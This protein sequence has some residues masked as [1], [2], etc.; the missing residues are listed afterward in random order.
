M[1]VSTTV[2]EI[3][4]RGPRD[5]TSC[6]ISTFRWWSD[7][8]D[9]LCE[10]LG[11]KKKKPEIFRYDRGDWIRDSEVPDNK[12]YIS[13]TLDEETALKFVK[14]F[15][16]DRQIYADHGFR[17]KTGMLLYGPPG[18]GK[19][20]FVYRMAIEDNSNVYVVSPGCIR[21]ASDLHS[22]IKNIEDNSTVYFEDFDGDDS[23]KAMD[24]SDDDDDERPRRG[25]KGK[26]RSSAEAP[27]KILQSIL[28]GSF[29]PNN[30]TIFVFSTNNIDKL[31]NED[32]ETPLIR[33]ARI[34]LTIE[35][36]YATSEWVKKR[37]LLD[38]PKATEQANKLAEQLN[39][40]TVVQS[41][42]SQAIFECIR[43][44]KTANETA[45]TVLDAIVKY[46]DEQKQKTE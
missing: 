13:N 38:F 9:R 42:F 18:T 3:T 27:T 24:G 22:A 32:G 5:V 1:W 11:K 40:Y 45:K 12:R 37:F 14:D 23:L 2:S 7:R 43:A 28:D 17:Y 4:N 21:S 15:R 31:K 10:E 39:Q 16:G 6:S 19:N 41:A 36:G 44:K 25:R 30:G 8:L 35:I 29:S 46:N 20:T 34:E 26:K 33:P